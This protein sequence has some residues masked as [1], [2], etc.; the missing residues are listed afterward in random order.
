MNRS[1]TGWSGTGTR[2]PGRGSLVVQCLVGLGV[3]FL[4]GLALRQLRG[5]EGGVAGIADGIVRAWTNAFRVIVPFLVISQL[6]VALAARRAA[7]KDAAKLGVLVPS[8]FVGLWA[9][10]AA[11]T[12]VVMRGLLSLPVLSGITLS[13]AAPGVAGGGGGAASAASTGGSASWV[14]GVIPP[15][16]LLPSS[17][18]ALLGLMLFTVFFALAARRLTPELQRV[19]EL[20]STAMRDT[21]F[22]LVD[23]L[24]RIAPIALFAVGLRWSNATLMI[25]GILLTFLV[26]EIL[27]LLLA[28]GSL[29]AVASLGGRCSPARFAR[30]LI[31]AQLTAVT[32]RSSLATVPALLAASDQELGVPTSISSVVIPL[33]GATLKLSQAVAYSA[34]VVFLAHVLGVPLSA[35]QMVVFLLIV[36]PL[37]ISTTGVPRV[38]SGERSAP[39]YVSIGIPAHYVILLGTVTPITDVFQTLINTTGYMT[40]NVLVARFAPGKTVTHA[41]ASPSPPAASPAA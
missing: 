10:I 35:Q 17:G 21:M 27:L 26:L 9:F 28:T 14:D 13:G 24:I 7:P 30:A 11:G 31:P 4:S 18:N 5:G 6:Y 8:V 12:V 37:A 20:G 32:T 22:V 34:R 36:F 16:L 19:L 1:E 38:M 29:Y 41:A 33:A 23:W 15:D 40:V 3:G 25:G 2:P 39:A